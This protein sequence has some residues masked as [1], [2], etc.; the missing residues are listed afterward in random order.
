[1][2]RDALSE[3]V[4]RPRTPLYGAFTQTFITEL[5][6]L[7]GEG[8]PGD[9]ELARRLDEALRRAPARLGVL[10]GQHPYGPSTRQSLGPVTGAAALAFGH[11][12]RR[13]GD[14]VGFMTDGLGRSHVR[15][16]DQRRDRGEGRDETSGVT[17]GGACAVQHGD[18]ATAMG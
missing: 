13:G 10:S 17:L 11:L 4:H 1:M 3:A 5:G 15:R 12:H 9:E 16:Q 14:L 8:P 6:P 7:F 2:L 18:L